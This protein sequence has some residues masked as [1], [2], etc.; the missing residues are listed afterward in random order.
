MWSLRFTRFGSRFCAF[1][2]CL[3]VAIDSFLPID[4]V[5]AKSRVNG[6]IFDP[7]TPFS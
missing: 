7:P 1:F 4:G 6:V 3:R 5:V 2:D